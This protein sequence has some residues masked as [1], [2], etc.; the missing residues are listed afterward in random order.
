MIPEEYVIQ[1]ARNL[2]VC[3][4]RTCQLVYA[5]LVEQGYEKANI[6]T[7]RLLVDGIKNPQEKK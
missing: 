3:C 4:K 5:E 7:L 1:L 6:E 2:S